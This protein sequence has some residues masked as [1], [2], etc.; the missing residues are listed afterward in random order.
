[1]QKRDACPAGAG[2]RRLNTHVSAMKRQMIAARPWLTV[3]LLPPYAPDLNPVWS[4]LK[5]SLANL[6][7][8]G[9]DQL[10]ALVKTRLK[11]MQ[12][13]PGLIDGFLAKTDSISP[14]V[15]PEE[16]R[17]PVAVGLHVVPDSYPAYKHPKVREWLAANPRITR[18]GDHVLPAVLHGYHQALAS[19]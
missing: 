16:G 2:L 3:F 7:K 18:W 6:T 4:H 15:T 12:H 1:M 9:I 8:Q 10:A 11:R 17:P 14:Y 19:A 5:R 13:R